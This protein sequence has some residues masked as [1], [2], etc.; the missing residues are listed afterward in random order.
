MTPTLANAGAGSVVAG[1]TITGANT[2]TSA[3][4]FAITAG[5][6][7]TFTNGTGT[8]LV[9]VQ[10]LDE[11]NAVASLAAKINAIRAALKT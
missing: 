4:T 6:I 5:T 7:T 11:L 1:A 3:S 8:I 9:K 10:N 2:G